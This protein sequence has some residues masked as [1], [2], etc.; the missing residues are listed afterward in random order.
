MYVMI[1]A[2]TCSYIL[3]NF[4]EIYRERQLQFSAVFS[5][6]TTY[7]YTMHVPAFCKPILWTG[8]MDVK[9]SDN[10]YVV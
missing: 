9:R 1:T 5:P 4:M 2:A 8:W 6:C 7:L 10:T 3:L